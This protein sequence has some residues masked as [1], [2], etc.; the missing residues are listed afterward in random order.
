MKR[1]TTTESAAVAVP[2]PED[3]LDRLLF[4][5]Y[6]S[7]MPA[8]M[9][10]APRPRPTVRRTMLFGAPVRS[11]LALAAA[12]ALI[13]G[14]LLAYSNRPQAFDFRGPI[15][16]GGQASTDVLPTLPKGGSRGPDVR[17]EEQLFQKPGESTQ[18]RIL[19]EESPPLP[20]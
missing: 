9:P 20:E 8:R 1:L 18:I 10:G 17:M 5:F 14:G 2:S 13:L 19:I 6:R 12:V 16:G 7:E 3:G 15:L 11:R 4:A